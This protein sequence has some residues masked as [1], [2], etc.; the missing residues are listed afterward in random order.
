[1]ADTDARVAELERRLAD[2]EGRLG[3]EVARLQRLLDLATQLNATPNLDDLLALI[4][5]AAK[6]MVG[7]DMSSLLLVDEDTDELVFRVSKD[8]AEVRLPATEGI[9]GW[10]V[11]RQE[12]VVVAD[13]ASDERF[14]AR[15]GEQSGV[16]TRNLLAVPLLAKGA[17]V[18]V[19]EVMNK[20][21]GADFDDRDVATAQALASLAAVAVDNAALYARLTEE[22]VNARLGTRS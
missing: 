12:P 7:A 9:A 15:V 18:G 17:C 11:Q 1:M 20:R 6:E 3:D 8:V 13:P 19:M 5:D 4:V 2:L 10:V 22:L 21:G 14:S 16:A